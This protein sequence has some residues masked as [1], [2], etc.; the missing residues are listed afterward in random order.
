[1]LWRTATGHAPIV[2]L[3]TNTNPKRLPLAG[4]R[5]LVCRRFRSRRRRHD[6]PEA[7]K[8]A[9][10]PPAA[11]RHRW[12]FR[13]RLFCITKRDSSPPMARSAT[14]RSASTARGPACVTLNYAAIPR[15]SASRHH[16]APR[17]RREPTS[18]DP[19]PQREPPAAP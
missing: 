1:M 9:T 3:D 14:P 5:A 13:G 6:G 4:Q 12:R 11:F 19:L 18:A 16:G 15:S 7:A 2:I 10:L 17:G 8:A